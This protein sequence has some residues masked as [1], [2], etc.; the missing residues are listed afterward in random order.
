MNPAPYTCILGREKDH[1]HFLFSRPPYTTSHMT[2]LE[3]IIGQPYFFL[4]HIGLATWLAFFVMDVSRG[5]LAV[6]VTPLKL[7]T[8]GY[9]L[10][11]GLLIPLV[12][13]AGE[14]EVPWVLFADLPAL[15]LSLF[16]N[17]YVAYAIFGLLGGWG[18]GQAVEY[19][20]VVR[21]KNQR[22]RA[23][24]QRIPRQRAQ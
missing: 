1:K 8:M 17:N 15:F 19:V 20:T 10:L 14:G 5:H 11:F 16:I 3:F 4:I 22:R 12:N 21:R 9:G 18:L 24:R 7:V 13:S 23:G 2:T 6:R